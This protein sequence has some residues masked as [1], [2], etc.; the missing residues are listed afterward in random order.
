MFVQSIGK[1]LA[2][3]IFSAQ[4]IC[5]EPIKPYEFD[6]IRTEDNRTE[7]KRTEDEV[8]LYSQELGEQFGVE[9]EIIQ[10]IVEVESDYC[11]T[12]HGRNGWGLMQ[13]IPSCHES[14][15]NKYGYSKEDLLDAYKNMVIGTDCFAEIFSRHPDIEYAL[16]CYNKGEGG[17]AAYGR[18]TSAYSDAVMRAYYRLK[19]E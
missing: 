3:F 13:I 14:R 4:L 1:V 8:V 18:R 16:V 5:V 10:A 12:V 17:A 15:L 9:P 2:T 7:Q 11:S 19:G 6:P